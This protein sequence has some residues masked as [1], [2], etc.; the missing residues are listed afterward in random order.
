MLVL[1]EV[2]D[3]VTVTVTT[4]GGGEAHA[5][6][7]NTHTIAAHKPLR[8]FHPTAAKLPTHDPHR[9]RFTSH[10]RKLPSEGWAD[11]KRI[12]SQLHDLH[13]RP[14]RDSYSIHTNP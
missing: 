1:E 10:D 12:G 8:L 5:V 4:A 9:H 11:L 14:R 6:V 13:Q 2:A 7:A 3:C